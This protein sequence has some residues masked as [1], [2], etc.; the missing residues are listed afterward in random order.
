MKKKK[1]NTACVEAELHRLGD[2]V[3]GGRALHLRALAWA[4]RPQAHLDQIGGI[5]LLP[6][7]WLG[8][9]IEDLYTHASMHIY[10]IYMCVCVCVCVYTPLA[11]GGRNKIPKVEA[12]GGKNEG[13]RPH[14]RNFRARLVVHLYAHRASGVAPISHCLGVSMKTATSRSTP[15]S[16]GS[17]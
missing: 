11:F 14:F 6:L 5:F 9:E 15:T 7:A 3:G 2:R 8:D 12:F 13:T 10:N 16:T 1:K 4:L 17:F